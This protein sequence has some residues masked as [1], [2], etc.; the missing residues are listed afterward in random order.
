[1]EY[2]FQRLVLLGSA[3]YSR[4]EMPL[5]DSV[6]L[7]A[8]NNIGKTS[9]IN[10][11][12]YLLIINR[13]R[14]DFG[15]HDADKSR[16]FY[17]PNNSAYILLEVYLPEAGSVVFGC[18]GKGV[19]F[20]YEYFAYRGQLNIDEFCLPN[21]TVVPQP[22]LAEHLAKF[23]HAVR[24]YNNKD[25]AIMIYGQRAQK[26]GG[27]H[28]FTVFRLSNSQD[29]KVYQSVLTRTL[30]L[31]RLKSSEVKDYLLKIFRRDLPDASL[32]FKKVWD[33]AFAELNIEREQLKAARKK[34]A[35][36]NNLEEKHETRKVLRGK[37]L[38]WRPL[39]EDNLQ[40]WHT[41]Y[42][43]RKAEL[44]SLLAD[45]DKK[46]SEF[47]QKS[48][49]MAVEKKEAESKLDELENLS[50]ELAGLS[51]RFALIPDIQHMENE[52][53]NI[54]NERD[55]LKRQVGNAQQRTV[56]SLNREL[57]N[58]ESQKKSIE[59]QIQNQGQTLYEVLV[60]QLPEA[61]LQA[62]KRTW[63]ADL[64]SLG[65]DA[66]TLDA[67]R[68]QKVFNGSNAD[69]LS[70]PG[71]EL[72]LKDLPVQFEQRSVAQL[73]DDLKENTGRQDDLRTLIAAAREIDALRE[74]ISNLEY[75]LSCRN[76]DIDAFLRM[77]K[78]KDDEETR[79]QNIS[80][81]SATIAVLQEKLDRLA[82]D[83]KA[84]TAQKDAL[85]QEHKDLEQDNADIDRL[86]NQRIDQSE[87][88]TWLDNKAHI[89][90]LGQT[91][92]EVEKL[93]ENL[94]Q[95]VSNCLELVQ[96]EKDVD[97]L[98]H[99]LHANGLTRY[100]YA[101]SPEDEVIRLIAFSH[102]LDHEAEA[103]E[104]KARTAVVGV[105]ASLRDLNSG[106]DSLKAGL[107]DFN[108]K[109][110]G[111]K[112]SDLE[113]FRV[114]AEDETQLVEAINCLI[115]TAE[116]VDSGETFA[117]FNHSSVMDDAQ[118]NR[119]KSLL[120]EEGNARNG[121]RI[122][123]LFNLRFKVGKQGREPES[124]DDID[125]AA[126]NGTVLMA[127]LVTGLAMLSLMHD[128]RQII[129][130]ICYLDEALAL[131]AKNQR[132]LIETA[133]E[134][135]FTLIFASPSPLTTV[136]YCVPIT[137]RNGLNQISHRSRQILESLEN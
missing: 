124:F 109:I 31:D 116:T 38:A 42:Q 53:A 63:S 33:T 45:S 99:Q 118:L 81:L 78:L 64:F 8:P 43:E 51:N 13:K 2:G 3:G 14:M 121:L 128:Q 36:L 119:A 115:S 92:L 97:S 106:L 83:F 22:Q 34:V 58:L 114:E 112:L 125:G 136:R 52:L 123:D 16:R 15:A 6:S 135:G 39:I 134:F 24:S 29:A 77:L 48:Q 9:L 126:S 25:F 61:Q 67:Q 27:G 103:L 131:D 104:K 93:S 132:S 96:L 113:V 85:T 80:L 95:Y 101:E 5:D 107:R 56:D 69:L 49:D 10:A 110:S 50:R 57:N 32:D 23:G 82:D 70:I 30:R 105:A 86:R 55:E 79:Q 68:L 65:H 108:R 12:Q 17:F 122:S 21:G 28:E 20:E 54:Q 84:L 7:V 129:R 74:K 72:A 127:K 71:L 88:F 19:S 91:E 46:I 18:V 26:G 100:Q 11:L 60:H 35:D 66:F 137:N 1:M 73:Q 89:Q 87:Y 47:Y 111:R 94:K 40:Q 75:E 44:E 117:L 62:L 120:I 102:N 133:K 76:K 37:V 130:S 41:S 4:A 90:W 59:R 98:I